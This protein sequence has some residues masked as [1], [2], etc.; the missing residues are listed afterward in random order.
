M[1]LGLLR[2]FPPIVFW[3]ISVATLKTVFIPY[4]SNGDIT[5][6]HFICCDCDKLFFPRI[7]PVLNRLFIIEMNFRRRKRAQIQRH[8]VILCGMGMAVFFSSS[9][10]LL[11][12]H[13]SLFLV[14]YSIIFFSFFSYRSFSFF[15]FQ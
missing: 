5:H 11:S 6:I 9:L 7:G 3:S 2:F 12:F 10:L 8:N 1:P 15:F 14:L 4:G 13:C